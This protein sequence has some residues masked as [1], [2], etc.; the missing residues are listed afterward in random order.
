MRRLTVS[1]E[2]RHAHRLKGRVRAGEVESKSGALR[3]ILEEYEGIQ[4]EREEV[5]NELEKA[6]AERNELRQQLK[7]R[8]G[9]EESV[10][11]LVEHTESQSEALRELLEER[12]REDKIRRDARHLG[13][14]GRAKKW[15]FGAPRPDRDH[16][17]EGG[18]GE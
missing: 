7:K 3:Q 12:E 17:R 4:Q 18:G 1:L 16:D 5:H 11:T 6:R 9:L 14:V 13:A 8:G 15:L 10:S 2:E